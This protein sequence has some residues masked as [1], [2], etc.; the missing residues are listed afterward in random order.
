METWESDL[1][2]DECEVEPE[3]NAEDTHENDTLEAQVGRASWTDIGNLQTD[4]RAQAG[5]MPD[6]TCPAFLMPAF[7]DESL[8][9]WFLFYVPLSLI[10]DICKA[11]NDAAKKI[12]WTAHEPWKTLRP[13]EFLRWAGVWILMTVY[14]LACGGR[15][16]YW[17]GLLKFARYIPERRFEN[18]LRAFTLPQYTK[19]DPEWGGDGRQF[20]KDQKYDKFQEVRKFT[21]TMR[22]QFQ[23]AM[24]PGGWLCIDE[25]MFSWL[26]RALKLP[27][28]KVIKRKPHPIGLE[29][30]TTACAV[31][32]VIIDYEFQEGTA[33]MAHFEYIDRTNRSSAWLLRLTKHWHNSEPRTVIADAAF[34]Q[35]RA[36]VALKRIGGLYLIG[37]V[38]GC[39]K[40]FPQ[41]ALRQ[42]CGE[43]ERG[44]L[45]CLTKK[46]TVGTGTDAVTVYATGWRCTGSMVVTYVHTG[47]TNAQGTD[48]TKRKYTQMTDGSITT[49]TYY[50]KRPKVSSE[51]QTR[52]GEIDGHNYR[53]QSGKGVGSLEK[54]CITR[55]TKGRIFI[56]IISWVL[57]NIFLLKKFFVW[58]G[59]EKKTPA[60]FQ[61]SI[62]MALI[63]NQLIG[64]DERYPG[65]DISNNDDDTGRLNDM[66][67]C[68]KRPQYKENVCR[69]CYNRTTVYICKNCSAPKRPKLRADKG[70]KGGAKYSES[71]YMRFCRHGGCY[72]KHDCGNVP[73]RRTKAQMQSR[74]N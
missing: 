27:G 53:M 10:S 58:G 28:W 13:G 43:Y 60:A 24:K 34:A 16:L 72:A 69:H 38:K 25:S 62:A 31:V 54:V 37:N 15:R 2:D 40:F 45:V 35:V 41:S 6:N 68:V 61:E 59:D 8:L 36:A 20:Y 12:S 11:T 70:P 64:E 47:G 9:N 32:G 66:A 5:A 63:H 23:N 48:R 14:P 17:R 4:P 46:M 42:E 33:A 50:V 22:K 52:K 49:N 21:D 30:K 65:H 44:K 26:G 67:F 19:E 39:H 7:R 1:E 56:S 51:Y 71:G 57:I 55:N 73:K 74:V 18:I 29:A 3:V